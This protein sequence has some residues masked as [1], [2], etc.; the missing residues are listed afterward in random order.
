MEQPDA[1]DALHTPSASLSI[2]ASIA[3]PTRALRTHR[4][5][6]HRR[7]G[8]LAGAPEPAQ[9]VH[10][11]G[12]GS[13][14]A[15]LWQGRIDTEALRSLLVRYPLPA[16]ST[17]TPVYAL[18][19]S[20]WS[21]CDA[22]SGL[23]RGFYYHPSRHSAGQPI[24]AGWAY[25]FIVELGFARESWVAPMD[26]LSAC[27]LPRTPTRSP[28]SRSRE[29]SKEHPGGVMMHHCLCSMCRIRSCA[30][31]ETGMERAGTLRSW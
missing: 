18:D 17:T 16:E 2:A 1:L 14:Y 7:A 28:P 20:V 21:R 25:Q 31:A 5:H 10:R 23:E 8:P 30:I 11:R 12:W 4:C 13:L 27:G 29:C 15:A 3:A 9:A 19:V 6:P 24:V 26:V 22:E